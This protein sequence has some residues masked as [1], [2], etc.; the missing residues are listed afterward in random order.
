M[1]KDKAQL[2]ED[3]IELEQKVYRALRPIVPKQWLSIDLTMPQLKVLLFLFIDG[4]ARMGILAGALG[5][6][7]TTTTG[8]IDRLVQH[9][10]I[11]RDS[12][13]DDRR[14][15]V[16][17]LSEEGQEL[18]AHLWEL[19]QSSARSLLSKMTMAKLQVVAE[20]MEAIAD[21]AAVVEENLSPAGD[22]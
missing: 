20:G 9:G 17:R 18:M 21:A 4:P 19:G 11:V 12:D 1:N 5:V 22:G 13:P 14:A 16:C 2:I 6:S 15:V 10:L 3:I 7:M 8:I